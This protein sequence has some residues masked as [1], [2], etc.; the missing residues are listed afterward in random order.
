MDQLD[1]RKQMILRA[2]IVEY[3]SAAEPVGSEL[4]TRKY[5][6]GV[7]SATVRNEL[8]EMSDLG[9]LEQ[10]HTS[11]GRIPSDQGYRY[12][13]DHLIVQQQ[14]GA[15][16]QHQVRDATEEG[17]VL[18]SLLSETTKLLSR[19]TRLLSAATVLNDAHI[20]ARHA[21]VTA[22][23][24][25][26]ALLVLVLSNGH[27]EN[28]LIECPPGLT[29]TD[30]GLVNGALLQAIEGKPLPT[31]ARLRH[32]PTT[33]NPSSDR[34]MQTAITNVRTIARELTKGRVLTEGEEFL[35]AQPEFQ[36]DVGMLNDLLSALES[37][38]LA[39]SALAPPADAGQSVTIG[40]ENKSERLH[41]FTFIRQSFFV[42]DDEAGTLA[43][44]G[45][46]RLNYDGS[47]PLLDFAAKAVSETLTKLL[48]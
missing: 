44:I 4:L 8:A 37:G 1:P 48:R 23:G 11:A 18:Q 40:K 38:D 32:H 19:I 41:P 15:D 16:V 6:L 39:Y 29:L 45:P 47:I 22:L 35:F 36:K 28:R 46:T 13:V 21:V 9:L 31:L 7:R 34:L 3:V 10:P 5:Q 27:V 43:L 2:V 26:T 42:G 20:R 17:E 30:L 14:P 24:P 12:Y 25:E 33:G